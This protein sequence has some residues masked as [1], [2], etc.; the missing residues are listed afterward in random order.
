L[1]KSETAGKEIPLIDAAAKA[2]CEY[3]VID[4]GWYDSGIWWDSVGEWK[5]SRERFPNGIREVTDYIRSKGMVPGI[6][7]ELEVIGIHSPKLKDLTDDC[8]FVRHGKRIYDRSRYQLDFRNPKVIAHA[9]EVIDRVV[10]EY[11]VGYIKMDYNIEPGIGTELQADSYG[12]GLL[13]HERAYLAWLDV[14][15]IYPQEENAYIRVN[16]DHTISV[17]FERPIMARLFEIGLPQSHWL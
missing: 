3:F 16:E 13:A 5:E 15:Q 9:N 11:G 6:W 14:R 1:Q 12:E 7:L 17:T 10:N 2:G 4:A 8:F